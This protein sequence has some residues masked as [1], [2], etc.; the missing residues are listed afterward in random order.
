MLKQGAASETMTDFATPP[1]LPPLNNLPQWSRVNTLDKARYPKPF[2]KDRLQPLPNVAEPTSASNKRQDSMDSEDAELGLV[3]NMNPGQRI[4]HLERSIMFLREQH[5]EVLTNLHEEIDKLK[6]ENKE[7]QFKIVMLQ[8]THPTPP[9]TSAT[10]KKSHHAEGDTSTAFMYKELSSASFHSNT[11][12]AMADSPE[13]NDLQDQQSEPQSQVSDE[14]IQELKVIFLEEEIKELKKTLRDEKSKNNYLTQLLEQS[15]KQ[16]VQQQ[17]QNLPPR[18]QSYHPNDHTSHH[19]DSSRSG[20]EASELSPLRAT[21]SHVTP[22]PFNAT[23]SPLQVHLSAQPARTPTL[24]EC[25][26][27]IKHLAQ[28]NDRQAHELNQLKTDLRDVLYSHKWT[29]D[30]YLLAKAYIAED[31]ANDG[32]DVQRLPRLPLKQPSR[33]LP[34]IAYIQ[35][36]VASLPALNNTVGNKAMERRKRTQILQKARM[37][38]E[39]LQ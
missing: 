21:T 25:E 20:G 35:R 37:R 38:R 12:A 4:Q 8:K 15:E 32:S 24:A 28:Q 16:E 10:K 23:V 19:T 6:R 13:H 11:K 9:A 14:K 3:D 1:A 2:L 36:D 5:H 18:S 17:H 34:D 39:V 26:I 33:K 30:A 31:D 22:L 27:L 29:P 7:L